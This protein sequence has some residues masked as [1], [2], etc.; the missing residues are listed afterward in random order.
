MINYKP[1]TF[2]SLEGEHD[3]IISDIYTEKN[4]FYK[5][6]QENSTPETLTIVFA[7]DDDGED[8]SFTQK[9]VSPLTGGKG[10]FQQLLD[11]LDFLPDQEGGEFDEQKLIGLKARLVIG[12]NKKGFD[13][14][15][16]ASPLVGAKPK[17]KTKKMIENEEPKFTA[18]TSPAEK[19]EAL[20]FFE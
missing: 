14:V 19:K 12:K 6:E 13:T 7:V 10:L 8:V 1:F 4:Q 20:D 11:C 15:V 17:G 2:R 16:S 9:F 5:P 18:K 3:A